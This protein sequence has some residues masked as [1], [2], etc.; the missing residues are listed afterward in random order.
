MMIWLI[1]DVWLMLL[2]GYTTKY[3]GDYHN[4]LGSPVSP[5]STLER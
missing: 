1:N 4:A 5:I 3:I 2:Q